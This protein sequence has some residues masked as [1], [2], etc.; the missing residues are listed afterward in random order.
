M[1][2]ASPSIDA[3]SH[4]SALYQRSINL[5]AGTFTCLNNQLTIPLTKLNAGMCDC[6][7]GSDEFDGR[8]YCYRTCPLRLSSLQRSGFERLYKRSLVARAA[9]AAEG[10][11]AYRQRIQDLSE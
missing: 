9:I 6:C 7:D 1:A 11:A 5:S 10:S 2:E 8:V 4:Y 3:L